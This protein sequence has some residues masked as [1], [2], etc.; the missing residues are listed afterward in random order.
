M[1][2]IK[3]AKGET[4]IEVINARGTG[5]HDKTRAQIMRAFLA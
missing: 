3:R 5:I 2:V 1:E 4:L